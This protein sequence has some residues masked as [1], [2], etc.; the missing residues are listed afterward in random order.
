MLGED[1]LHGYQRDAVSHIMQTKRCGLFLDMGLGKTATTLTA[2]NRLIYE[3]VEIDSALIIAPKRV[4]RNVWTDEVAKWSHLSRLTIS[5]VAGTERQ[6]T[7]ALQKKA[8]IY[9]IGRDSVAW[10]CAK[11]GGAGLPFDMLVLDESSSFKNHKSVRF[12][13]L[14][15]ASAS[16]ARIV[17]LTG[18]PAPNSLLDLWGQIY[19]I[20]R[21]ERLGRTITDFRDVYFKLKYN[22]FDYELKKEGEDVIHSKLKD[23]CISMK[24][25][26][27]LDLPERI[28]N[29]IEVD[30]GADLTHK[31]K[32]FEREQIL[33]IVESG[34]E[35]TAANAAALSNKLLQFA[36]GFMY[37][38]EHEAH[39]IHDMKLEALDEIVEQANGKP[40]LLAWT[41][42]HD[43]DRIM[44]RFKALKPRRLDTPEDIRAWN[45][46]EIKLLIMHP[47]SG[48]HGLNLQA[49]GSLVVW[50]GQTWSL[51]LYQ[52][53]NA[54]LDRQGQKTA[55]IVHHLVSKGTLDGDV[56][57]AL[58]RKD[59][60]QSFLMDAIALKIREF[61]NISKNN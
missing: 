22:G 12:K 11:Y 29:Y 21:G 60:T 31:Y 40:I 30:L 56:V 48:G 41:Y 2:I 27:Y 28:N 52:Q 4:A 58:S 26:D 61:K 20:D 47:A 49:G 18:T 1:K 10:L 36:N 33:E 16:V 8:D 45:A 35:V 43:A 57:A 54:R 53:F 14:R 51:E 6:R 50:Y 55:V 38:S 44:E 32:K 42:R 17:L 37:D 25:A 5:V 3:E 7:A 23:I 15:A 39:D 24:A 13:A 9:T 19:L 59:K 34:G 46:G